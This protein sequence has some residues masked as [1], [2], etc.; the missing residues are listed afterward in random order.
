M[1]SFLLFN[2]WGFSHCCSSLLFLSFSSQYL[3]ILPVFKMFLEF[4]L[5]PIGIGGISSTRKQVQAPT[6]HSGLKIRHCQSWNVGHSC[7]SDLIPGLG[8]FICLRAA[9]K[10]RKSGGF[11]FFFFSPLVGGWGSVLSCFGRNQKFGLFI[12]I[13]W[14]ASER[15]S[16]FINQVRK[17]KALYPYDEQERVVIHCLFF[18]EVFSV[19]L[20]GTNSEL[21]LQS[22]VYWNRSVPQLGFPGSPPE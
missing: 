6:Q 15:Q 8:A 14:P 17:D 22:G 9:K 12:I 2:L 11:L 3:L 21:T 5:W 13:P 1:L 16:Y 18:L 4:L 10:G 7:G 20:E 19:M